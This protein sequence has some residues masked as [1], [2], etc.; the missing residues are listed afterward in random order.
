MIA[1]AQRAAKHNRSAEREH[2]EIREAALRGPKRRS[3]ASVLASMP[4]VRNDEDFVRR[5]TADQS[6]TVRINAP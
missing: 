3:L 6:T 5:Q 4:N 2:R 1:A